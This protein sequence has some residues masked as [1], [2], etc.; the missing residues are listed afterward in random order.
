MGLKF[1]DE[2]EKK[3]NRWNMLAVSP[4]LFNQ[5]IAQSCVSITL[6]QF[7]LYTKYT[8]IRCMGTTIFMPDL[9]SVVFE[10][11]QP[12]RTV[13]YVLPPSK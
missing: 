6:S 13:I 8:Y 7:F 3:I 11:F 10:G 2:K 12:S 9:P 4:A 5:H 1:V